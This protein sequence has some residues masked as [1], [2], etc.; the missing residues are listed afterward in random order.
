MSTNT[1][2][3]TGGET[4][5]RFSD[6]LA[7][8]LEPEA[9]ESWS[10]A[11]MRRSPSRY[12][13]LDTAVAGASIGGDH[14]VGPDGPPWPSNWRRT[15][16]RGRCRRACERS[17]RTSPHGPFVLTFPEH[18]TP[19]IT[20]AQSGLAQRFPARSRRHAA[21]WRQLATAG[22]RSS[23]SPPNRTGNWRVITDTGGR[24]ARPFH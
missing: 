22:A 16:V 9:V 19:L 4:I 1:T 14:R 23:H 13:E 17:S 18:Q 11:D 2:K 8:Y 10:A 7:I 3:D 5:E 15:H 12:R 20:C 21:G 6:R 24:S